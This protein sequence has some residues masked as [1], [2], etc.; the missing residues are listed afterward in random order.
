[1]RMLN[2]LIRRWSSLLRCCLR[3]SKISQALAVANARKLVPF[4]VPVS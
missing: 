3:L 2:R 4:R 1:M